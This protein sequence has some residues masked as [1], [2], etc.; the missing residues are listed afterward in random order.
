VLAWTVA[1]LLYNQ[2]AFS[3]AKFWQ[4]PESLR[5]TSHHPATQDGYMVVL[6]AVKNVS[7]RPWKYITVQ[8]DYYD[9]QNQ[10]VDSGQ[11]LMRDTLPPGQE[12]ACK[13]QVGKTIAGANYD[14]Y[15]AFVAGAYDASRR[16]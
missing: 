5:V 10:L 7:A 14:H 16:P 6:A 1:A 13:V 15:R 4:H 12:R 11:G 2:V 3:E 9:K 8:A